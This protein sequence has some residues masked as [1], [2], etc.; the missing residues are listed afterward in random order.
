MS[1]SN[2]NNRRQQHQR[3]RHDRNGHHKTHQHYEN[4][5]N[6]LVGTTVS[7]VQ[8]HDQPTGRLTTGVVA[9]V[10]TNS[11]F[12]PRGIKVRLQDGTLLDEYNNQVVMRVI[13]AA[14]RWILVMTMR[15]IIT[16]SRSEAL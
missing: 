11:A 2:N 3:R 7:I 8:K 5:N 13:V 15:I 4:S 1:Y 10:L 9:E 6:H 14:I 16:Q 12:H